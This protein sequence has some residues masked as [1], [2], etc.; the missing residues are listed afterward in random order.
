[1]GKVERTTTRGLPYLGANHFCS[2]TFTDIEAAVFCKM[3]SWPFGK[4]VNIFGGNANSSGNAIDAAH[5]FSVNCDDDANQPHIMDCNVN[6]T[7]NCTEPAAIECTPGYPLIARLFSP[8]DT[9]LNPDKKRVV[10]AYPAVDTP[11]Q[12]STVKSQFNES[13]F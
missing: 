1:M 13:R 9:V 6:I 12:V 5:K 2:D 7:D 10:Y 11:S 4:A 3:L 8:F